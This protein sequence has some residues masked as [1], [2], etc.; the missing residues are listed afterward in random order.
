MLQSLSRILRASRNTALPSLILTPHVAMRATRP[1]RLSIWEL[2]LA[3]L[4]LGSDIEQF[5]PPDRQFG[6]RK[7]WALG[8][9]DWIVK[10][11]VEIVSRLPVLGLGSLWLRTA[12]HGVEC[13]DAVSAHHNSNSTN[14]D[15][16]NDSDNNESHDDN[17]NN[18]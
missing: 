2:K 1:K 13:L 3:N 11:G 6:I 17:D 12:S 9:Q 7:F 8:L 5:G 15:D 4:G 14:C 16:N 10:L 18:T